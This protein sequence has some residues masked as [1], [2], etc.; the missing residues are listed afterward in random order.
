[1]VVK[2]KR[3]RKRY[4]LFKHSNKG[5][6]SNLINFFRKKIGNLESKIKCKLIEAD[7]ENG[8]VRVD[9][10]LL[11]KSREIMNNESEELKIITIKT[12]G[13]IKGLKNS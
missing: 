10:K 6:K 2:E 9:H 11:D 7:L 12:S 4:I 1:M 13:T 8:I 5:P 3:G